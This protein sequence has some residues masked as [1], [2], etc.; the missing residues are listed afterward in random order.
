M[1]QLRSNMWVRNG[2]NI[3]GLL[4]HY[5]ETY[6]RDDGY[7]NDLL[8][9]CIDVFFGVR[10]Q[11]HSESLKKRDGENLG[12]EFYHGMLQHEQIVVISV[13]S[14]IRL[15][16]MN[17]EPKN[18]SMQIRANGHSL[19]TWTETKAYPLEPSYSYAPCLKSC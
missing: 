10:F 1:S 12:I 9:I 15:A 11:E 2:Q 16:V 19:I 4:I 8:M 3:R 13:V 5:R 7:D 17:Q 14:Q 18:T 6:L